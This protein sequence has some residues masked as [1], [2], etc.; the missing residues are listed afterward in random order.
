[1]DLQRLSH[2][3]VYRGKVFDLEVDE[4]RYASGNKGVREVARH[5]GGAVAVPVLPDGTIL[6]VKQFRY[7]LQA[8]TLEIP[9]G[10]LNPGED[11]AAA[12]A[13]ELEEETG[14]I[15]GRLEKLTSL[16]TTPGFCDEVLHIFLAT[17]MAPAPGGH[18]REEG[19]LGMT[20]HAISLGEALELVERGEITDS[21][22]IVG[23]FLAER[24]LK[25]IVPEPPR[26]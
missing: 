24:K 6:F 23:L 19:E 18:R 13:R 7:P 12:A 5:P 17:G 3:V 25:T 20:I 11:P 1:M 4:I 14:W 2:T 26:I 21:K 10:K 9:A 16:L 8:Y 15:A 22:T